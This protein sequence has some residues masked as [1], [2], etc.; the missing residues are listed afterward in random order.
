MNK[1][2]IAKVKTDYSEVKFFQTKE[3]SFGIETLLPKKRVPTFYLERNV[4]YLI[5][6]EGTVLSPTKELRKGVTLEV[7]PGEH[8]WLETKTD[9]TVKYLFVDIPQVE[10]GDLMWIK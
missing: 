7:K 8:F 4:N 9:K 6:L 10:E 1:L 2:D 3:A 5:I